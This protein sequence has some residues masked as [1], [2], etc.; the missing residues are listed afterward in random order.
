MDDG[1][2]RRCKEVVISL[3]RC[4]TVRD[5]LESFPSECVS[6]F[7]KNKMSLEIMH[8][9]LVHSEYSSISEFQND[10]YLM[11]SNIV[12]CNGTSSV[13]AFI[14]EIRD[15]FTLLLSSIAQP[16]FIEQIHVFQAHLES[17][18]VYRSLP[19]EM[20]WDEI[21]ALGARLNSIKDHKLRRRIHQWLVSMVP[22]L[23]NSLEGLD[24]CTLPQ[25]VL[26]DLKRQL[27]S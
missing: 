11:C 19:C 6:D 13:S 1:V 18:Q 26:Q 2:R 20:T 15:A 5:I 25:S 3:L 23:E 24:L 9:K 7:L 10:F 21:N 12:M 8:K 27:D 4:A 14:L 16:S 22:R 17:L